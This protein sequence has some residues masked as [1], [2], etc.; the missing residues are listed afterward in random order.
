MTFG[1]HKTVQGRDD[2]DELLDWCEETDPPRSIKEF[3]LN[4]GSAKVV[5]SV[6]ESFELLSRRNNL[7]FSH[8]QEVQ[9][10]DDA[11]ELLDWCEETDPE[12]EPFLAFAVAIDPER[13]CERN[14]NVANS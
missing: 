9:G 13:S 6:A 1:H 10:R 5:K 2:A 11:D 12:A 4:Y 7:T 14:D 3:G 8:H